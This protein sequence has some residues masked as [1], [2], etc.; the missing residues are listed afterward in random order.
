MGKR[1]MYAKGL[2]KQEEILDAALEITARKGFKDTSILD[3]AGAVGLSQAGVLHHFQ[4]RDNLFIEVLRRHDRRALEANMPL[5]E[6]VDP[7]QGPLEVATFAE[8][9]A[10]LMRANAETP[11]LIEI[12]SFMAV[13]SSDPASEAHIFFDERRDHVRREYAEVIRKIQASHGLPAGPGAD[14]MALS[15]HALADGLQL[16]WL[17]ERDLDMGGP[18]IDF[19]TMM[20]PGAE[21]IPQDTNGML[22]D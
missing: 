1:G 16:L 13:E 17:S 7:M 9:L 14:S 11:G 18:I 8:A 22:P 12:Y 15:L 4:S 5:L 10:S 20:L 21:N 3:I 6:H 2:A 19:L